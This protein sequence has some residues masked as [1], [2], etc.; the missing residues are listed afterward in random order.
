MS[1]KK[2]SWADTESAIN[3]LGI[4]MLNKDDAKQPISSL[5]D[6]DLNVIDLFDEEDGR[7]FTSDPVIDYGMR[8]RNRMEQLG[9]QLHL[10]TMN[11]F[12]NLPSHEDMGQEWVSEFEALQADI[13]EFMGIK[14]SSRN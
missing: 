7:A 14:P 6:N 10:V 8:L 9:L 1:S 11:D 13:K 2:I 4:N 5:D 3:I 12:I